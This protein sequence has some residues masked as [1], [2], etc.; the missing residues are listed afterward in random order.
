MQL[1]RSRPGT[2]MSLQ[3]VLQLNFRRY[4]DF[5]IWF[6]SAANDSGGS[7]FAWCKPPA[8]DP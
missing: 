7:A 5:R 8:A 4:S 6:P 1:I 2:F 3:P